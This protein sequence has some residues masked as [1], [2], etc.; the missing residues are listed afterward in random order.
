VI[1][2]NDELPTL[3]LEDSFE[4]AKVINFWEIVIVEFYDPH[5]DI[6]TWF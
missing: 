2:P 6:L 1:I 4:V 3:C 5:E